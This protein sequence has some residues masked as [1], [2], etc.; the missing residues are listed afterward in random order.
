MN[1][2]D[3]P[4]LAA[5]YRNA[6][7][8]ELRALKPGNVHD[9]AEGHG[10]SVEDFEASARVS[11][12]ALTRRGASVGE[13]VL[14][15]VEATHVHVGWNTNLG[16]VLLCAPLAAAA[17]RAGSLRA[18]LA[19]VLGMLSLADAANTFAA[20]R[21]ASPGGLGQADRHDVAAPPMVDLRMAMA[22]AAG[23][24]R[25][26]RAYVT[27]FA[28]VFEIGLAALRRARLRGLSD[29]WCATA[30]H[31]T[32]LSYAP[33]THIERKF[34]R[35]SA[36]RVRVRASEILRGVS[37][38]PDALA[39]LLAFD[40]DLKK[41]DLNPGTTADFTVATLFAAALMHSQPSNS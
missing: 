10:G 15:A 6:C 26:A 22:A 14:G 8:A 13:R 24:D 39:P 20:I 16:I 29:Q 19:E 37:L 7:L 38:G 35:E 31:M 25:I 21:L 32:F 34:G 33:D 17:E 40:A 28:E 4:E 36:E 41:G 2:H 9:F 27:E 23:R 1:Y 3:V 30:V 11:A 5:A 18:N 12:P